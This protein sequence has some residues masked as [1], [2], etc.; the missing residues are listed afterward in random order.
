MKQLN[1]PPFLL[2]D[3]QRVE[4]AILER[5]HSRSAVIAAAGQHLLNSGG[6]RLRA[7]LVLLS[8][9][10]GD[11]QFERVLH[12]ATAVELIHAASLTHDDLVDEAERR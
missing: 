6:K 8:A 4:Q 12:A 1:F 5:A 3:L 7:A 9:C 11:Y 2:A 10:L